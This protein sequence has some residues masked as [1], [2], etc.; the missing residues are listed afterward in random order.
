MIL[1][2][3]H[4][5]LL[6]LFFFFA[7]ILLYVAQLFSGLPPKDFTVVLSSVAGEMSDASRNALSFH[8]LMCTLLNRLDDDQSCLCNDL[9]PIM[10]ASME[11]LHL[12]R[13]TTNA[14]IVGELYWIICQD[15]ELENQL[16]HLLSALVCHYATQ[17]RVRNVVSTVNVD[18]LSPVTGATIRFV[19]G[20]AEKFI[21]DIIRLVGP[22]VSV[23]ICC[24]HRFIDYRVP[25]DVLIDAI[26]SS[27]SRLHC[28]YLSSFLVDVHC[29]AV[30]SLSMVLR[31]YRIVVRTFGRSAAF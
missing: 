26:R 28:F 10:I 9:A 8:N 23:T 30:A 21:H 12:M 11:S 29:R 27:M 22:N 24:S 25:T 6:C 15:L 5:F 20:H 18:L 4:S 14:Q 17:S 1:Y 7:F 19:G 16:P 3:S 13:P 31:L 2:H